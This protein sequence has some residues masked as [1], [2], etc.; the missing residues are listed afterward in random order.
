MAASDRPPMTWES[1]I[2]KGP[3]RI[4]REMGGFPGTIA[5]SR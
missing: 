5:G 1:A 4:G 3:G 2:W